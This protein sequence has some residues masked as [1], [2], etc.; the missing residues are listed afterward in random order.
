MAS[1][2]V[3]SVPLNSARGEHLFCLPGVCSYLTPVD[4]VLHRSSSRGLGDIHIDSVLKENIQWAFSSSLL[5]R[6]TPKHMLQ[7]CHV[8]IKATEI[9]VAWLETPSDL[10]HRWQCVRLGVALK[11][12]SLTRTFSRM[13][14]NVKESTAEWDRIEN[15]QFRPQSAWLFSELCVRFCVREDH[16]WREQWREMQLPEEYKTIWNKT[17]P[18]T[19]GVS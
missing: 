5:C 12:E 3:I 16:C 15:Q 13:I 1:Q 2:L 14:E 9:G 18:R 19:A 8:L 17:H 10:C 7:Q 6:C 11:E 4:Y